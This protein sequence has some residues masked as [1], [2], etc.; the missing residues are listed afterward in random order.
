LPID[1]RRALDGPPPRD[2]YRVLE[3][4]NEIEPQLAKLTD[5]QLQLRPPDDDLAGRLALARV[6]AQRTLGERPHDEQVLGA[7]AMASGY[8]IEML[9][10]E[11]KTLAAAL[12]AYALINDGPVHIATA[13]DYLAGRDTEWMRPLYEYLGVAVGVTAPT[14][15]R[16][17]KQAAYGC[18]VT[19]A[20][21]RELAF[22]YLRDT[23]TVLPVNQTQ[24][25]HHVALIDEIDFILLDEARIP[26]VL[27]KKEPV[28][29]R[30]LAEAAAVVA[31]LKAGV[32][33]KSDDGQRTAWLT[34]AGVVKVERVIGDGAMSDPESASGAN[35]HMAL[36]AR[37]TV[38]RDRDYV[39]TGGRVHIVDEF[40]GR[41]LPGRRWT[42]GLHQAV[43]AKEGV[44]IREDSRPL[45]QIT[46]RSYLSRYDSVVGMSGTAMA[47]A[48]E[49]HDTYGVDVVGIPPHRPVIREDLTDRVSTTAEDKYDAVVTEVVERHRGGQPLLIGTT[50]VAHSEYLSARLGERDIAHRVL[51]A[52]HHA[53]EAAII[54]EAGRLGAVTVATNMAGRGVDIKL[55]GADQVER[56]AVSRT[57]G[58]CVIGV[59]RYGSRRVDDQLR[60]RAGRQ[61][62]PGQSV[63]FSSLEDDIVITQGPLSPSPLIGGLQRAVE[64]AQ[65]NNEVRDMDLRAASHEYDEIIDNHYA[66]VCRFREEVV[67]APD[68]DAWSRELLSRHVAA[69]SMPGDAVAEWE[70]QRD[71]AGQ[72]WQRVQRLVMFSVTEAGWTRVLETMHGLRN[73]VNL[74]AFGGD[75]PI[76]EWRRRS[77]AAVAGMQRDTEIDYLDRLLTV[78]IVRGPK[79]V[80]D[81]PEPDLDLGSLPPTGD[82]HL[83][84]L[85]VHPQDPR[86][87]LTLEWAE[88]FT[89]PEFQEVIVVVDPSGAEADDVALSEDGMTVYINDD[90]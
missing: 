55:G 18:D 74:V 64:V 81:D 88:G 5:E 82:P 56:E 29:P 8:V 6:A 89:G 86:I 65:R 41:I 31:G 52:K 38:Q 12:A 9:T 76:T 4:V 79:P 45:A 68:F 83:P 85:A 28:D 11:G 90:S 77:D 26:F 14:M 37:A 48:L 27:T 51:N 72:H 80:T 63:F 62:D 17:A 66:G 59:E 87:R 50:T 71:R 25:G 1:F 61:G 21:A 10:G 84:R 35:I 69:G 42:D 70:A 34:E 75:Y 54:A 3:T 46:I 23:L 19:Y 32:D 43:E 60:G 30:G 58:L 20:T 33:F 36:R 39:V 57:G 67:A 13:N 22:D 53:T 49:F 44:T 47:A 73:W 7:A 15:T 40:T 16:A 24:R 78:D 2:L